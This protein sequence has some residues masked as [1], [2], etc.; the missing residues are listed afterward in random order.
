MFSCADKVGELRKWVQSFGTLS[1]PKQ[2]VLYTEK[3]SS[4][5]LFCCHSVVH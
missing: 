1:F 5:F 2:E 3:H 4:V